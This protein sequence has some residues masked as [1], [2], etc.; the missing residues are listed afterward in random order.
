[1]ERKR[2]RERDGKIKKWWNEEMKIYDIIWFDVNV[3]FRKGIT[4]KSMKKKRKVQDWRIEQ[5]K[6]QKG[7]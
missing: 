1:M 4:E 5:R 7:K 2:E 6:P 3:N